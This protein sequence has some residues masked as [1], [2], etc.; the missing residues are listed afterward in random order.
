[1]DK[2]RLPALGPMERSREAMIVID[3][4]GRGVA[5]LGA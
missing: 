3:V 2:A 5:S 4:V 1:M